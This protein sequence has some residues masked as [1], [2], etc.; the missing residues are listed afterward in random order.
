MNEPNCEINQ[1]KLDLPP[2]N[3]IIPKDF[4]VLDENEALSKKAQRIM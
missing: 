4:T 3:T 2:P 1:K